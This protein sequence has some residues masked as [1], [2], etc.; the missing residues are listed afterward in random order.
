MRKKR[1][2]DLHNRCHPLLAAALAGMLVLA[3]AVPVK[4]SSDAELRLEAHRAMEI[5]S[6][7]IPGW[8]A[9]PVVGAESA[10]SGW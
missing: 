8:P 7:D 5:Q 3:A 2:N 10:I 6:N 4:A 9:G 1:Q